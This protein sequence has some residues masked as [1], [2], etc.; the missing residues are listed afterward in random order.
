MLRTFTSLCLL[1]LLGSSA[2]AAGSTIDPSVPRQSTPGNPSPLSSAPIRGNFA[3]A[4]NDINNILGQSA[5]PT[6]P[7]TP[8]NYQNWADTSGTPLTI[9]KTWNTGTGAWLP[10]AT[11]NTIT[12]AYSFTSVGTVTRR[13][14]SETSYT[15][16]PSDCGT[17]L[18]GTNDNSAMTWTLPQASGQFLRC[19]D[20][21][22]TNAG[23]Q[24]LFVNA[25]S[26]LF[27][28]FGAS[29]GSNGYTQTEV[30]QGQ[31]VTISSDHG[32]NW[33]A[34][35]GQ[36][37]F[38]NGYEKSIHFTSYSLSNGGPF[39]SI[40]GT[41]TVGDVIGFDYS[42][43]ILPSG[44]NTL[45][46]R[47][48]FTTNTVAE[49][50]TAAR[51]LEAQIKANATLRSLLG[52]DNA[53]YF[54]AVQTA[55]LPNPSW[56][57]AMNQVWPFN[58]TKNPRAVVF[59]SAGHTATIAMTNDLGGGVVSSA[60]DIGSWIG[61]ARGS[62][63]AGRE[64]QVGDRICGWFVSGETTGNSID[65]HNMQPIYASTQYTIL[66]PTPG[67]AK[68]DTTFTSGTFNFQTGGPWG[69]G[70]VSVN[71]GIFN[72]NA[73]ATGTG[74]VVVP[75]GTVIALEGPDGSGAFVT[76]R[77]FGGAPAYVTQTASGT[78]GVPLAV[79]S[80]TVLGVLSLGGYN[81]AAA[82]VQSA[83]ISAAATETYTAA[84]SGSR[85]D[86]FTTP[87]GTNSLTNAVRI[88]NDGGLTS[89]PSVT[90]GSKGPGTINV[91]GMFVNGAAVGACP[92]CAQTN[93]SNTFTVPQTIAGLT[94]TSSFTATGLVTNASLINSGIVTINGTNCTLG[95][96]CTPPAP[97]GTLTGTT[98]SASVVASSLTS[99]GTI[100][101]LT[102]TAIGSVTPGTGA[103]TT[104]T[105]STS[106]TSPVVAGGS[107][108]SSSLT[109]ESTSGAG[110]TDKIVM[111]TGAQVTRATIDTSGNISLGSNAPLAVFPAFVD[112]N[113]NT[114]STITG[115]PTGS[116][117]IRVVAADGL[118][119]LFN[120]VS[121]GGGGNSITSMYAGGTVASPT[122][123]ASGKTLHNVLGYAYGT[124][125]YHLSG[126]FQMLTDET[127]S[128]AA[129]GTKFVFYTTPKTTAALV[130]AMT[131]QASGGLSVGSAAADPGAG[132]VN[133]TTG[134]RVANGAVSGHVL[135]GNGTNFVDAQLAFSDLS[136]TV[137]SV[138][139]VTYPASYTSGGV[140]YASGTGA[141]SSSG[142]M[143]A[144]AF[145]TGGGAGA[146]PSAVAI[147][148]L[149]RGNGASAPTAY[150]GTSCTS[151]FPRSLDL[152]GA[153]T[154]ASV[155]NADLTN[156][157]VTV[158]GTAISLGGSGTAT[159]AAGTLTGATLNST[160]TA[161]S[162]TSVGVSLNVGGSSVTG[163]QLV[164]YGNQPAMAFSDTGGTATFKT[165]G[166][167]YDGKNV[168]LNP[169]LIMQNLGDTGTFVSS[170][171]AWFRDGAFT[172]GSAT[173]PGEAGSIRVEAQ[174]YQPNIT[175][176][177]AAQTGTVC[178][179][180]GTGKF[181]ADTT[182]GCLTSIMSAKNM[183]ERLDPDRALDIVTRLNPFAFRY[184]R[185]YGDSGQY[186]Q[187]GL[188]AEEVA[189]VD[190]RL[191]GRDPEGT[192]QGVRY[193]ESV[194]VLV[195]AI[196][197][198]QS[199]IKELRHAR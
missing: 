178:W 19:S 110:T 11:L 131:I 120:V 12:G 22:I 192:L 170:T 171:G 108:A 97:A 106:A 38:S 24:P 3:A 49:L 59:N 199:E 25:Q 185:G 184:K 179:T 165:M 21:Q 77:G 190:E 144:N 47:Y 158:N 151:Q 107:A 78:G 15:V 154:C 176:T 90:G 159:A 53:Q 140:P 114:A 86:I 196:K 18:V 142:V 67:V 40:S 63:Y 68:A 42:Y 87:T 157:S 60:L 76:A 139:G 198:L 118:D 195:G 14:I 109:L 66:D 167:V 180:T 125:A 65:N 183:I 28:P 92:T 102:A 37:A 127:Q 30:S 8:I 75:S 166:L 41:P 113:K 56:L 163:R 105:A 133:A 26:S 94:V 48:T 45:S 69:L 50:G 104:F 80:G 82:Y 123:A 44:R 161:S 135:R 5:G 46:F 55:P 4:Y 70:S 122:A 35:I 84:H 137:T 169:A 33:I 182:V 136:G 32:G 58:P 132:V 72:V 89:P 96:S 124:T 162:L 181:T 147:T 2:I 187:F 130:L 98:L 100:T 150:A 74:G 99:L 23:V 134:Y 62:R 91:S 155:A 103:F 111:K 52:P 146:A 143:T 177:S 43:D 64:P 186:E 174:H 73:N 88:E 138:N 79:S 116:A 121:A 61:C 175:T 54:V 119:G 160:V 193:Q 34:D 29:S 148:G 188:G 85:L 197:K 13:S 153:A 149:V 189:L 156:S 117:M 83:S 128:D 57:L 145:V 191:V 126:A 112:I 7:P 93:V 36:A 115:N 27:N 6:A 95:S 20:I 168:T 172:A 16:T 17:R 141:I 129:W 71:G 1:L 152:N 173:Y 31:T 194:A 39:F 101:S 51:N 81:G 9:F 164:V 10:Y